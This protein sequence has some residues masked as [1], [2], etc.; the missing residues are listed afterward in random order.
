MAKVLWKGVRLHSRNIESLEMAEKVSGIEMSPSQGGYNNG[1]VAASAGTHDGSGAL[2]VICRGWTSSK[3]N[4]LLKALRE[5]GWAAW[6][7]TEA[8]GF[9]PHI[10]AIMI[11]DPDASAGAKY[12][13][14][15]YRAGRNGL[16]GRGRDD[17]PRVGYVT[18]T[19]SKHNPRN[20]KSAPKVGTSA[21][22]NT[23][24]TVSLSQLNKDRFSGKASKHVMHVQWSLNRVGIKTVVDGVWG[25]ATQA[26]YDSYR[27]NKMRVKDYTGSVGV[28]SLT[29]LFKAS[30]QSRKVGK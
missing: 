12:Q 24:K 1:G 20:T 22:A 17:G 14:S 8:Q 5:V 25:K 9:I 21:W 29:H 28:G 19:T 11:G 15:E 18:W 2:D 4:K 16:R 26:S 10:H 30:K 27:K 7:R 13:V 23:I 3:R 6:Y